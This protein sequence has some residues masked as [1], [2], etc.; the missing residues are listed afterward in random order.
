M[1]MRR[2]LPP[3]VAA[4]A[5]MLRHVASRSQ[6]AVGADRIDHDVASAVIGRHY[7]SAGGMNRD[8]A[9]NAGGMLLVALAQIA[10][11]P[12]SRESGHAA[13]LPAGELSAFVGGV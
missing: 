2:V 5:R 4:L 7:E 3:R 1:R 10:R 11:L 6:S 12:I 8:M 9:G 13:P